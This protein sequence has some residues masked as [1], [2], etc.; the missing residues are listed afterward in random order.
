MD[1]IKK[2]AVICGGSS[3]EREI[4]LQSGSGVGNA[5]IELGY[6]TSIIDFRDLNDLSILKN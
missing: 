2:I 1:D 4:S 3:P 6:Q 5:L